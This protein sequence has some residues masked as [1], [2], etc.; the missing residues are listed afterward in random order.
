VQNSSDI[1]S[2]YIGHGAPTVAIDPNL[3]DY[4]NDLL[5][6]GKKISSPKSIVVVS[7]H[8]QDYL[9]VQLTSS[10]NPGIIYDYYGFPQEM[11]EL[12][13]EYKGNPSLAQKISS[14]L[15]SQGIDATL[16]SQQGIDHGAWIPLRE[17]YPEGNIPIIQMSIPVP[18][19]PNYLFKIGQ[20]L[21][22]LRNE[23]IMFMGSGNVIHNLRHVMNK[24]QQ[25]GGLF[26][27]MPIENWA[28]QSD[29]WL[30][31]ELDDLNIINLLASP[32]KMPNFQQAAPTT[33]HF[34]PLYFVLGTLRKSEQVNHFHESFQMGS[35]SMRSFHSEA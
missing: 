35:I 18:R 20:I 31:D 32:D 5:S 28:E 24:A 25:M 30:K 11:Y 26:V 10:D 23:G 29:E 4:K 8:W 6:F 15:S 14:I 2:I 22:P 33:E 12:T 21:A 17:M 9:P 19:S 16:N 34:D 27:N 3:V 7:A 1:P 13:Y